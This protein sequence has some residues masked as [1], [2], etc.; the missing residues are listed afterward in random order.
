MSNINI[1]TASPESMGVSSKVILR[2]I[3]KLE[4]LQLPMHSLL[5][6]RYG[7]L[8]SENYWKPF[9]RGRNHRLYS[10]SKSL[11]S[12]AIGLM[13]DEGRLSLDDPVAGFFPEYLPPE[14]HE[15][16]MRATIRD[17]LM[18]ADCHD[19]PTYTFADMNWVKTWFDTPPTHPAGAVFSYNTACSNVCCAIVEKLAGMPFIEYLYPRLL[20]PIGASEGI[21]CIRSPEG[22]SFGGSGVLMTPLDLARIALLCMNKGRWEGQQ[23]INE[24]YILDA[25]AKQIDNTLT[26]DGID[27][28]Q[29]YGY[30]FWR[31]RNGGF[32]LNGMGSQ[33]AVCLPEADLIVVTTG[34]TQDYVHAGHIIF[35]LIWNELLPSLNNGALPEDAAAVKALEDCSCK[36]ELPPV[37]GM[38]SSPLAGQVSGRIYRFPENPLN[39]KTLCFEFF[40]G[41]VDMIF[42]KPEGTYKLR[43]GLGRLIKQAFPETHYS[44]K[45]IGV[46]A[47]YGYE[48]WASAAWATEKTLLAKAFITDDYLG[49]FNM[50]ATFKDG[51]VTLLMTKV[52]E[53]FLHDYQG[54]AASVP[55]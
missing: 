29:G 18:M 37:P 6:L 55:G 39:I 14:P 34:D 33:Y 24:R 12:L 4:E 27:E 49:S 51:E 43:F 22:Y 17:M 36:L 19:E 15:Y 52:A 50:N 53:N 11:V 28:A 1:P 30:Q 25:T 54:F 31:T 46:P 2:L 42:E 26:S 45:Q 40:D 8:I 41:E 7:K 13:S 20:Q 3:R 5:I 38:A 16:L 9:H 23:L 44:G 47:G 35:E 48:T 10:A 32:A 21:F